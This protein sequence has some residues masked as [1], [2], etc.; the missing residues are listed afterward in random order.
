[1]TAPRSSTTQE[2]TPAART[3]RAATFE[4]F[5]RARAPGVREG[6]VTLRWSLPACPPA[7]SSALRTQSRTS[8]RFTPRIAATRATHIPSSRTNRT[9]SALNS[10]GYVFLILDIGPSVV[11]YP[12]RGRSIGG[13]VSHPRRPPGGASQGDRIRM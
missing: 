2:T 7:V 1:M 5:A 12:P 6:P 4:A 10:G 13:K 3:R 11:V 9:A 8:V